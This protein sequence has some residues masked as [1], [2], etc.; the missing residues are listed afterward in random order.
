MERQELA[1]KEFKERN[2]TAYNTLGSCETTFKSKA[3]TWGQLKKDLE[4]NKIPHVNMKA[5]I[6]ETQQDLKEDDEILTEQD[7]N[8]FLTPIRVK[9]GVVL[10]YLF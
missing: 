5:V 4:K 6:G 9:S 2:V 3:A 7:L 1:P 8:L 10:I